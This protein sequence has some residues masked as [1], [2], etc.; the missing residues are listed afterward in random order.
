[1]FNFIY[2]LIEAYDNS[3]SHQNQNHLRPARRQRFNQVGAA[4]QVSNVPKPSSNVKMQKPAIDPNFSINFGALFLALL[5]YFLIVL[6]LGRWIWNN[7]LVKV[8]TV[9]RP[10]DSYLD[11]WLL[12]ILAGIM[13]PFGGGQ[14]RSA[15]LHQQLHYQNQI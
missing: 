4:T 12:I 5:I 3:S 15:Q 6:V 13:L 10:I 7:V 1:M 9:V 14:F 11:L 8:V 2:Q